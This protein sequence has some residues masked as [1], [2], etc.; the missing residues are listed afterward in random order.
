MIPNEVESFTAEEAISAGLIEAIKAGNV[1]IEGTYEISA[2]GDFKFKQR[3]FVFSDK[4]KNLR[5]GKFKDE[6]EIFSFVK[7]MN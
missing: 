5:V 4:A 6:T 7:E 2:T 1:K 3:N